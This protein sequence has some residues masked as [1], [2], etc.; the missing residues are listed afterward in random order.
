MIGVVAS[1]ARLN[2]SSLS[3]IESESW[4]PVP[5]STMTYAATQPGCW[6][7][8]RAWS[9]AAACKACSLPR[10]DRLDAIP[11][12]I[13]APLGPRASCC[14][15]G[16]GRWAGTPS[17]GFEPSGVAFV[18]GGES[19]N[20][21]TIAWR[22]RS[23]PMVRI[24]R[25]ARFLHVD[26]SMSDGTADRIEVPESRRSSRPS[27]RR[28]KRSFSLSLVSGSVFRVSTISQ[29][30]GIELFL[31]A[32]QGASEKEFNS[33]HARPIGPILARRRS[34]DL[35]LGRRTPPFCSDYV[36]EALVPHLCPPLR[37]GT[38][39]CSPSI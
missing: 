28:T 11:Q 29:A 22:S 32:Y 25:D 19:E 14:L 39:P 17:T 24:R 21:L 34:A 6:S 23:T 36:V 1:I 18:D 9:C 4:A 26:V 15:E 30:T 10:R 37:S 16:V 27:M 5:R 12:N 20:E 13:H 3:K 33:P 31:Q 7:R 38:F 35:A 2:S 8:P